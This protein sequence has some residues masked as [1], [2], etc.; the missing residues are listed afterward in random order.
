MALLLHL[1]DLHVGALDD[2]Q[3]TADYKGF[4]PLEEKENRV[5]L[6]RNSLTALAE[7][8]SAD[9]ETLDS[10][11]VTGDVSSKYDEQGFAR[12]TELLDVLGDQRP[13]NDR[14]LVLPGNH[15]VKRGSTAS[16]EERYD[17]F[18]KYIRGG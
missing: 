10:V 2:T 9:G 13:P 6:L 11:V 12:L 7:K 1:S 16:T 3:V 8:L 17:F 4:L 14:V 15:D 18:L 5:G